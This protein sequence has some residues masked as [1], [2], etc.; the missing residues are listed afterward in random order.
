MKN[1]FKKM[2]KMIMNLMVAKRKIQKT[3]KI[4]LKRKNLYKKH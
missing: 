2:R 4:K 1:K 3:K